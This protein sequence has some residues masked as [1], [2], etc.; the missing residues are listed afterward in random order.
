MAKLPNAWS[1]WRGLLA[2]V[3]AL[4][5]TLTL[6]PSTRAEEA[7]LEDPSTVQVRKGSRATPDRP[8]RPE[9]KVIA[10]TLDAPAIDVLLTRS[11]AA[12]K[13]PVA[14]MTSDEEFVRRACLDVTGRLP[15]PEQIRDFARLKGKDKRAKLIDYLL[16]SPDYAGNWARY[17]RDVVRFH[18]TNQN[19]NQVNY[20]GF[21]AW[22]T[23]QFAANT[24]WDEIASG[25]ITATGRSDENG[26][27]SFALA[28]QARPVELAGE[29]SRIFLGVQ[30]QCAQCHDHRTDKWTRQQ[31]HE[32]ASMFAG[33]RAR[34]APRTG[35]GQGP[36]IFEVVSRG[37]PRYTMPDLKDPQ[38]SIPVAPRFFLASESETLPARLSA[39]DRRALAASYVTG[40]DNPWFARAFVNRV[41]SVLMGEGFY[42]PVDDLGP[43]RIANAP[44]L[45][46]TLAE[47]WQRGGYDIRWL[48]R[49]ILNTKAYQRKARATD[50]VSG[51]T[52]FASNCP[53]RL[54][55]DQILDALAHAIDLPLDGPN[56]GPA[57]L[58]KKAAA[59]PNRRRNPRNQ[60]NALFGVD[61][62]IPHDEVLGTIPQSLF[63]MNS[64]QIAR[65]IRGNN[66]TVL[67]ELL[68]ST[69]DDRE[70]L[71][72]LY[73]RVLTRRPTGKEV[74][75]CARY[76]ETV[77]DR[78][79]AFEDILWSL[80]NSTEFVSRR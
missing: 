74:Q 45:I 72:T 34:R 31:F 60:F 76:L 29:V 18:A 38:K 13:A 48:F 12:S 24:P 28:H 36:P 56:D 68:A 46:D 73:L 53:S 14:P 8:D 1:R 70:V 21:E 2:A 11:L 32:F 39:E 54:P 7:R 69:A 42:N 66:G 58:A 26:A 23:E 77:G 16:E 15:G 33:V 67:A 43:G 37:Q 27:V 41:W 59:R 10:P 35:K 22:L 25:M 79:E 80:I 64:P 6:G 65:A 9:R 55:A 78:R 4:L 47:Q 17:W 30:I 19:A 57:G 75:T 50:T 62:S 49:T 3:L 52:P 40:Q 61:P 51:R 71:N 63:L 5:P 44:E 20:P